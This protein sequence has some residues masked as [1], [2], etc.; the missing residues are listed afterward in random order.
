MGKAIKIMLQS[1]FDASGVSKMR[2]AVKTVVGDVGD[3]S[4]ALKKLGSIFGMIG[5]A[6]GELFANI[7]K[8]GVWGVMAEL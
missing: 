8:G 4:G 1:F 6:E 5:G 7:L 2:N 3:L